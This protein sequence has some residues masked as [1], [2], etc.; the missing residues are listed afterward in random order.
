MDLSTFLLARL[1]E[2]ERS[3]REAIRAHEPAV[4][5]FIASRPPDIERMDGE[6]AAD[7][8]G[9]TNEDGDSNFWCGVWAGE[10]IAS[11]CRM[12]D[13]QDRATAEYIARHDPARA[14]AEVEAKRHIIEQV[15][16]WQ[17]DD[18]DDGGYY[19]C[20]ALRTE[21]LGDLGPE[22]FG[23]ENCTCGVRARRAKILRLLALP[24]ADHPDYLAEW[25]P[26]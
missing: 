21:P 19:C 2:D 11:I 26:E 14:L 8:E 12:D 18:P 7:W 9:G 5:R 23:E 17:H 3:A 16:R 10:G 24:Y 1:D 25:K 6:T 13:E 20:P 15:S 4:E 22:S